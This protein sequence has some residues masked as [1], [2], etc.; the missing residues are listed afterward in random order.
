MSWSKFGSRSV[1]DSKSDFVLSP[2]LAPEPI[3][4]TLLPVPGGGAPTGIHA[5]P[6]GPG[7]P[8]ERPIS[9]LPPSRG[10][11]W[12]ESLGWKKSPALPWLLVLSFGIGKFF[13][14]SNCSP[15]CCPAALT[16]F[17]FCLGSSRVTCCL[18]PR[19]LGLGGQAVERSWLQRCEL[20]LNLNWALVYLP[21]VIPVLCQAFIVFR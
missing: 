12:S 2:R 1:H 15:C 9:S 6:W 13:L 20:H 19:G 11:I 7:L 16:S 10:P 18:H 3:G 4:P 21:P 14:L 8:G 17:L 5:L